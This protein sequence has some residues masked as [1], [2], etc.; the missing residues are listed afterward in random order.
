MA[1]RSVGLCGV[2]AAWGRAAACVGMEE[3]A[4]IHRF[5]ADEMIK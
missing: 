5:P 3:A 4:E 2:V 1:R